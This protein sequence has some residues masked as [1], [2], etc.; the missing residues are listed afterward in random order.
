M[1]DLF[2][3]NCFKDLNEKL[4]EVYNNL[5]NNCTKNRKDNEKVI[6]FYINKS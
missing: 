3:K 4:V 2:N 6:K 5:L 1:E